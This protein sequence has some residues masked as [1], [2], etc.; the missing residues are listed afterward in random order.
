MTENSLQTV[1][2]TSSKKL[3]DFAFYKDQYIDFFREDTGFLYLMI[4]YFNSNSIPNIKT[5]QDPD[6]TNM[7]YNHY[8]TT[9]NCK[10]YSYN[11]E[12]QE[13]I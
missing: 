3:I 5:L 9:L 7:M 6:E 4:T 1:I 12:R 13:K 10:Y 11:P 2:D 8:R